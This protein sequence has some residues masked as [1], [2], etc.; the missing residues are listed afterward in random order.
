MEIAD[1][2][3]RGCQDINVSDFIC[4]TLRSHVLTSLHVAACECALRS[5][6]LSVGLT[7]FL[8]GQSGDGGLYAER[9]SSLTDCM[10][11][12]PACS[13]IIGCSVAKQSVPTGHAECVQVSLRPQRPLLILP[14]RH[15]GST[16]LMEC[17]QWRQAHRHRRSNPRFQ[18][19]AQLSAVHR[20]E[21]LVWS[22]RIYQRRLL[23]WV[24]RSWVLRAPSLR[25]RSRRYRD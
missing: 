22:R 2:C 5:S 17:P 6:S 13:P 7:T 20:P 25:F 4:M 9:T 3:A 1:V 12:A 18:R 14:R 23:G 19:L 16:Q 11:A 21:W 10:N 24:S 8:I 15:Y